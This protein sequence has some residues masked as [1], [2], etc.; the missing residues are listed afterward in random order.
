MNIE[1]ISKN[2]NADNLNPKLVAFGKKLEK[3]IREKFDNQLDFAKAI[4]VTQA[5]ISRYI[6]GNTQ[7]SFKA[8]Q[9]ISQILGTHISTDD[10]S[11]IEQ[12]GTISIPMYLSEVSA[13]KGLESHDDNYEKILFDK[14]WFQNQLYLKNIDN[15]FAVKV[16]GDSMEPEIYEGE[17]VIAKTYNNEPISYNNMYIIRYNDDY[18]IKKIQIKPDNILKII[19]LNKLY[20]S[21]YIDCKNAEHDF[22]ICAIVVGKLNIKSFNRGY[23]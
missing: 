3:L 12:N 14:A 23:V 17:M 7:P 9:R 5:T 18:L 6:S 2:K 4:G 8:L 11:I 21:L 20:D 15:I 19:S 1:I 16:N 10:I 22:T 13:G